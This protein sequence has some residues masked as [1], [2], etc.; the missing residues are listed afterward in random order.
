MPLSSLI[1]LCGLRSWRVRELEGRNDG[2]THTCSSGKERLA[3]PQTPCRLGT[4]KL[5]LANESLLHNTEARVVAV[6]C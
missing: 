5:K 2:H 1:R 3:Q 4:G 6:A